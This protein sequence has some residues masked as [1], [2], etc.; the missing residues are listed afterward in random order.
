MGSV[1][2]SGWV[3]RT[4][5]ADREYYR[6]SLLHV[7]QMPGLVKQIVALLVHDRGDQH[8]GRYCDSLVIL[9]PKGVP[10]GGDLERLRA[11]S[12]SLRAC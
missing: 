5:V 10:V 3:G 4:E 9:V 6:L 1:A 7:A 2:V 12:N 8:V 11:L